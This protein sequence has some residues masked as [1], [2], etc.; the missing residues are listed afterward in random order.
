MITS[1]TFDNSDNSS[2]LIPLPSN[3]IFQQKTLLKD[4]ILLLKKTISSFAKA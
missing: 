4:R 2:L 1:K 3:Q